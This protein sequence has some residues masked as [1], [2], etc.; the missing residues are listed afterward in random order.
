MF[1]LAHGFD[2]R[3]A[4]LS[5]TGSAKASFPGCIHR[6]AIGR[7]ATGHIAPNPRMHPG[8]VCGI[9]AGIGPNNHGQNEHWADRDPPSH[10]LKSRLLSSARLGTARI[11]Y[12]DW[13]PLS[14]WQSVTLFGRH[15]R[16]TYLQDAHA[17]GTAF[18]RRH[19]TWSKNASCSCW[20]GA[21]FSALLE[22]PR[23]PK[24]Q[25][26]GQ[27]CRLLLLAAASRRNRAGAPSA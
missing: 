8:S 11:S 19:T 18:S 25:T 22:Q 23:T 2:T 14:P 15:E 9:R 13:L 21:T 6:R 1:V 10:P 5:P 4:P 26:R 12:H 17:L 3:T 27:S 16:S 7:I 24:S 20:V